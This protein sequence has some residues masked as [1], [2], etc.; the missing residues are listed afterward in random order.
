M[1]LNRNSALRRR[2]QRT[3][4]YEIGFHRRA[5]DTLDDNMLQGSIPGELGLLTSLKFTTSAA[6]NR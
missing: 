5:V 6:N 4:S 3:V 1:G 2:V